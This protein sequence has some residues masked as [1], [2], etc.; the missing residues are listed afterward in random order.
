[1]NVVADQVAIH[2]VNCNRL[3]L[4]P[5]WLGPKLSLDDADLRSEQVVFTGVREKWWAGGLVAIPPMA[6]C[7]VSPVVRGSG[8]CV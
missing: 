8:V 1:M 3:V 4:K 5:K 6:K 7:R 2:G